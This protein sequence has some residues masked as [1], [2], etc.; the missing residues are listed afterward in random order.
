[1]MRIR[2]MLLK[3]PHKSNKHRANGNHQLIILDIKF[4]HK[5]SICLEVTHFCS[6]PVHLFDN[7]I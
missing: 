5:F 6:A 7:I 4:S 1:M 2:L 3:K